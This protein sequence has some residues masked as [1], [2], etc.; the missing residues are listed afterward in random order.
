[1]DIN[2]LPAALESILFASGSPIST[3]RIADAL[4]L[5]EEIVE[6]ALPTSTALNG[7]VCA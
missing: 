6:R 5:P 3:A 4:E 1:M 7:A 2:E